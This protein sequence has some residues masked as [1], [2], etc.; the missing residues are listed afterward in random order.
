MTK[1]AR[2][3][4]LAAASWLALAMVA[5]GAGAAT[6]EG[7]SAKGVGVHLRADLL[8]TNF[9]DFS[10]SVTKAPDQ[11]AQ[12][13]NSTKGALVDFRYPEDGALVSDLSALKVTAKRSSGALPTA[14]AEAHTGHVALFEQ[15]EGDARAPVIFLDAVDSVADAKCTG[16]DKAETSAEGT[17][18]IGLKI[19]QQILDVTPEPNT[20]IRLPY[21]G[22]PATANDDMSLTIILNEQKG[23]DA[24]TGLVVTAIHVIAQAFANPTLVFVDLEIA[25]AEASVFCGDATL[26]TDD[27]DGDTGGPVTIDKIVTTTTSDSL[28]ATDDSKAT[29]FRGDNVTWRITITNK[30]EEACGIASVTDTVPQHFSFV[31]ASGNLSEKVASGMDGQ[32]VTWNNPAQY[33]LGP[34]KSLTET[35]T[36]KVANDA[37]FGTYTNLVNLTGTCSRYTQGLRGPVDVIDKGPPEVLG[38]RRERP[39]PA[40]E[41]TGG[42]LARTGLNGIASIFL[43]IALLIG[44]GVGAGTLRRGD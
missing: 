7:S 35:I 34:G 3:V 42:E 44:A 9:T 6:V 40:T 31:S 2:V 37:P 15:G 24:G 33:D 25:R 20:V 5:T 23:N 26:P 29:A 32:D 12:N 39:L 30:G 38:E 8:N 21:T 41:I 10:L 13:P 4:S 16:P 22:D 11:A 43:G 14:H 36:A 27:N 17:R 1:A 18:L 19:G 28:G